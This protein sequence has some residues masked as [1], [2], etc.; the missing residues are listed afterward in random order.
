M[1][2]LIKIF[3]NISSKGSI[4]HLKIEISSD[5]TKSKA[6]T[7]VDS[8]THSANIYL[9]PVIPDTILVLHRCWGDGHKHGLSFMEFKIQTGKMNKQIVTVRI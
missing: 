7:I 8:C 1:K 6:Q 4:F 3:I 9:L 2:I 5:N